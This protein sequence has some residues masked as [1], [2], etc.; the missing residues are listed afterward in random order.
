MIYTSA[1]PTPHGAVFSRDDTIFHVRRHTATTDCTSVKSVK[2]IY[3]LSRKLTDGQP[4]SEHTAL[5][6]SS[7]GSLSELKKII[8]AANQ[9]GRFHGY[10][11]SII[12]QK[13]MK[14]KIS[15]DG[16]RG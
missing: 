7:R 12:A 6:N 13:N 9:K 14:W 3:M 15:G 1:I 16:G 11:G 10:P 8:P 4:K 2:P 5:R